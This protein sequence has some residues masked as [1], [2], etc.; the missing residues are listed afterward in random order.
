MFPDEHGEPLI[1][2]RRLLCLPLIVGAAMWFASLLSPAEAA[3]RIEVQAC[4][5]RC[6]LVPTPAT[7]WDGLYACQGRLEWVIDEAQRLL[8][9]QT[10]G[11]PNP[12]T[13]SAQCVPAEGAPRA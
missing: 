5:G 13:V 10:F 11:L 8:A 4:A 3:Y 2:W 6:F 7:R 12:W 1:S 9:E